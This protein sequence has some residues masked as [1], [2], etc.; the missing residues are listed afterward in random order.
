MTRKLTARAGGTARHPTRLK[1]QKVVSKKAQTFHQK[2]QRHAP[3]QRSGN[4]TYV[5]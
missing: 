2:S 3:T 5:V 1:Q 4:V